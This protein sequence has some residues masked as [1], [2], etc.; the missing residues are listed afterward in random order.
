MNLFVGETE[1]TRSQ[2]RLRRLATPPRRGSGIRVSAILIAS[3]S[4]FGE[5][6]EMERRKGLEP[7]TFPL[8]RGRST[9]EL[10]SQDSPNLERNIAGSEAELSSL[11]PHEVSFAV[12]HG[13]RAQNRTE[14][15]RFSD[16]CRDRLGYPG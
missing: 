6:H 13:A 7:S 3:I 4:P 2:V 5:T 14:I 11:H 8:A 10:P 15:A 9:T 16:A 12:L 1:G